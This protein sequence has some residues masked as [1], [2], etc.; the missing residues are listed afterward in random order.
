VSLGPLLRK[1]LL[2][3]RR[4]LGS[5][6]LLLV[7]L[8]GMLATGTVLFQQVIPRDTP[9][10]VAPQ[11]DDVTE[12]ELNVTAGLIGPF[13]TPKTYGS[14]D[15]ARRGLTREEV[16]G[17]VAVPHGI[18][19]ANAT[20][21]AQFYVDRAVVPYETPSL[22]ITSLLR[23]SFN[24]LPAD[25]SVE[26]VPLGTDHTL[27]AYLV[28][29]GLLLFVLVLGLVYVPS[30]LAAE[31]DVLDR[32]LVTASLRGLV[33]SKLLVFGAALALPVGVV[34]AVTTWLGYALGGQVLLAGLLLLA[35]FW[36]TAAFGTVVALLAGLR[37]IGRVVNVTLLFVAV[38]VSSIIYPPGFFSPLR[39][40]VAR[41]SPLHQSAIVVRSLLLKDVSA[42]LY[43]S[44]IA[45]V[46]GTL[47][48]SL[49][50]LEL[51]IRYRRR[52]L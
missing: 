3:A 49:L 50:A 24:A 46:V 52:R 1:E 31:R 39:L 41:L 19:E 10:A 17:V 6:L 22:A 33:A 43:A 4:N 47:L 7:V 48:V 23:G 20:L 5:I 28:P 9:V 40:Q 44:R 34:W 30:N 51:T 11:S 14:V 38:A 25:V 45:V 15:A 35:T 12:Q 26:R 13:T 32:L 36:Y 37:D 16:Y 2:W 42:S 27:S 21:T 18:L 8:P 29:V